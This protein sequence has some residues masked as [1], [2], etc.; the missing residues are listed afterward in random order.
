MGS[1]TDP[2]PE[3]NEVL[4]NLPAKVSTPI[5]RTSP[6]MT[7]PATAGTPGPAAPAG[8]T[9]DDP[10]VAAALAAMDPKTPVACKNFAK[11]MC[12]NS[13]VPDTS[14]LTMCNGYVSTVNQL[15]KQQ[16]PKA[17]EACKG[18]VTSAPM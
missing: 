4:A 9:P 10:Q 11:S 3:M 16:G 15:V 18:L 13:N 7:A 8:V 2:E 17:P 12:R 14:R 6:V 1:S 5:P